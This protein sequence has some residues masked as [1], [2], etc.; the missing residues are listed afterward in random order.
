L[1]VELM[2]TDLRSRPVPP[3]LV[4]W[5]WEAVDIDYA[6]VAI[7]A[8]AKMARASL[9]AAAALSITSA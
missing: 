6:P 9:M 5:R 3:E 8:S 7:E 2:H 4:R 1:T